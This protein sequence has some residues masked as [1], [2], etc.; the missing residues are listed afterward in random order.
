[1]S[2]V[3]NL[4]AKF[5]PKSNQSTLNK[6]YSTTSI[7]KQNVKKTDKPLS[8][9][10]SSQNVKHVRQESNLF[11][12]LQKTKNFFVSNESKNTSNREEL[13]KKISQPKQVTK[14]NTNKPRLCFIILI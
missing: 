1:M 5:E 8:K 12:M 3:K 6:S 9:V 14:T 10:N 7:K 2:K 11:S 4:A 13:K